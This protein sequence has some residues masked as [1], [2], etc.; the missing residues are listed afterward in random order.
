MLFSHLSVSTLDCR[1]KECGEVPGV[2]GPQ[3]LNNHRVGL[4]LIP[5]VLILMDRNLYCSFLFSSLVSLPFSWAGTTLP[6][7]K[8]EIDVPKLSSKDER[9]HYT[10]KSLLNQ[11]YRWSKVQ[12]RGTVK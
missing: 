3:V 4:E 10:G 6:D 5:E 1:M 11:W 8:P 9:F 2:Y 12:S 7:T